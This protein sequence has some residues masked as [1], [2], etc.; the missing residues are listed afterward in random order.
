M[1]SKLIQEFLTQAESFLPSI[2]GGILVCAREGNSYGALSMSL[3]QVIS[4]KDAAANINSPS[5]LKVAGEFEEDL[6]LFVSTKQP[7]TDDQSRQ[8]LDKLTQLEILLAQIRFETDDSSICVDSF[9]EE[10]FENL[11]LT[12]SSPQVEE[13]EE[14]ASEEFEMDEEMLEIFSLEAEELVQSISDN[15]KTLEKNPNHREALL[16][17][18]RNAHTLKGS[19]G[20]VGLKQ[21]SEV[22]H[23][24][25]DLLDY[26]ADNDIIATEKIFALLLVSTDCFSALA[27]GENSSQLSQ[28]IA[29]LYEDF[30]AVLASLKSPDA[31]NNNNAAPGIKTEIIETPADD[32]TIENTTSTASNQH[33]P[34]V[35]VSLEK[36]DDLV[37]IVG[38]LIISRSVFEQRLGESEISRQ[39]A[40]RGEKLETI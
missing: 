8:L 4:I 15:L 27:I 1:E 12:Q 13:P 9:I 26:V 32:G 35:R 34:V 33:R 39:L 28:K 10:S 23:R 37:K 7:L 3:R 17:I 22:A 38:G 16:E 6:K 21:L 18:R 24:V 31:G 36:L 40:N 19:A 20:I 2:R 11:W 30:D 25:E 14:T 5:I 29:R